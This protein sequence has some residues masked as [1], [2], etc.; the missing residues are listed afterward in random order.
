M[1]AAVLK[2]Y[3][4]K[5]QIEDLALP[6]LGPNQVLLK[7]LYSTVNPSDAYFVSGIYGDKKELPVVPGFEGRSYFIQGSVSSLT[8][9]AS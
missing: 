4:T 6:T 3:A 9:A 1:R 5:L 2:R 7:M 8:V